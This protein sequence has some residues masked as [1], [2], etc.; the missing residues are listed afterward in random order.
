VIPEPQET[1]ST[2]ERAGTEF[3]PAIV[4]VLARIADD[5]RRL[6]DHFD[7]PPNDIVDSPYIAERQGC[8]TT[9]IAD[10][11]RNGAIPKSC[12][13]PGTGDGRPWKFYRRQME[14]WLAKR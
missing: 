3:S 5:I 14:D 9:W 10:Q 2:N 8:T 1:L 4:E 11:A 7:P 13:V 6:A 12:I